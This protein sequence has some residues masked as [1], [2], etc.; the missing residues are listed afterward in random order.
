[1]WICLGILSPLAIG[2]AIAGVVALTF[3]PGP[4]GFFL[5]CAVLV[6]VFAA[7]AGR[8]LM[9]RVETDEHGIR[10][11]NWFATRDRTWAEIR[12]FEDPAQSP[13]AR[14]ILVD[15]RSFP[16]AITYYDQPG[17]PE[18]VEQ[19]NHILKERTASREPSVRRLKTE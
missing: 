9:L 17:T 8:F 12:R 2:L 1:M 18:F 19:L 14:A 7:L 11:A 10:V 4:W 5:V 15:G 13:R 6:S 3:V 16:I